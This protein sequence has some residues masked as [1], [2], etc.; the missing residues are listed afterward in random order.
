MHSVVDRK[1]IP[2][3]QYSLCKCLYSGHYT[4]TLVGLSEVARV[5]EKPYSGGL[6]AERTRWSSVAIATPTGDTQ[7]MTNSFLQVNKVFIYKSKI[8]KSRVHGISISMTEGAPLSLAEYVSMCY[9]L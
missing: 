8:F 4:H 3:G 2:R 5:R 7:K 1:H 9:S 6:E